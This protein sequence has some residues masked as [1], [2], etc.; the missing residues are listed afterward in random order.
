[1]L[2]VKVTDLVRVRVSVSMS[3]FVRDGVPDALVDSRTVIVPD[4]EGV[5]DRTDDT[6]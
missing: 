3:V 4:D 2:L 6:V 5:D 1:M